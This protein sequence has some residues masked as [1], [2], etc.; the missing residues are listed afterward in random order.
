MMQRSGQSWPYGY[1]LQVSG[2]DV[3]VL[4]TIVSEREI[5]GGT[6][7]RVVNLSSWY[8]DQPNRWLAPMM[9]K[10]LLD[11]ERAVFTDLTP[12]MT[13]A[14]MIPAFGFKRWNEGAIIVPLP[15]TAIV[16]HGALS[17]IPL[18]QV[19]SDA[20]TASVRQ[21]LEQHA[22]MG[23][24]A[25]VLS[26]GAV[27]HP[28]LFY[29]TRMK[30]VPVIYLVYAESRRVVIDNLGE[31]AR[32]LFREKALLLAIDADRHNCPQGCIFTQRTPKRYFKGEMCSDRIDY[33]YS[34]LITLLRN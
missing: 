19:P 26:D 34:E 7:S 13:V 27:W 1:L 11:D 2:K 16:S 23:C 29:W 33:A 5:L 28:L 4:L 9:L 15:W 17:V 18:D 30:G 10:C 25:G 20:L 6:R 8:I 24:V 32:F 12:T 31:I 3:G 21:M 22:E 14:R